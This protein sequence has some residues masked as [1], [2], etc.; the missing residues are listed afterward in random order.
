MIL[1]CVKRKILYVKFLELCGGIF[2]SLIFAL[3]LIFLFKHM[4][5]TT[6]AFLGKFVDAM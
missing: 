3:L 1:N 4:T 2:L 5:Y 6:E